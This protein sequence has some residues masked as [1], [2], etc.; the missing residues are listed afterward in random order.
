VRERGW[1]V[2]SLNYRLAPESAWPAQLQ[3]ATEALALLRSRADE[4]GIDLERIGGLGD[5]AG[6][7]LVALLGE[8]GP[9]RAPLRSV[10][11]WSGL[12]DLT[13]LTQ[14]PSSGG[15]PTSDGCTYRGLAA[16]VVDGLM[17]CTPQRC[18]DEYA[19]ASPAAT[20]SSGHAATLAVSSEGEQV[21][22]RQAWVMDAALQRNR[23]PSRVHVL[24]GSLHARGFQPYAWPLSLRFLAAT[25]TPE[26]APAYPR[27]SVTV[28]LD[29]PTR[30]GDA[31][32]PRGPAQGGRPAAA[33]RQQ[34]EPAGAAG[35]RDVAHGAARAAGARGGRHLLRHELDAARP[36]QHG[37]AGRLARQ[38]HRDGHLAAHGRGPV[39][40]RHASTTRLPGEQ[41]VRGGAV[42][43][44]LGVVGVVVV[45]VPF[46]LGRDDAPLWTTLLASLL[47]V[48]L[49][50]AL[51][52]LLRGA[53]ARRRAARRE[54]V[55]HRP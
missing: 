21:D 10:V 27:P 53:R 7:H 30:T 40:G 46:L 50:A 2:A 33:G 23:V 14:Q 13:G 3:D 38:R 28:T 4:L 32:R 48:G 1:T 31:G 5:S 15:C 16:K 52:G 29:L 19:L 35:R 45:V 44:G 24:P 49:G 36:R 42:L 9:G 20:V 26:T 54:R 22:P 11:T 37:L 55:V 51:L 17:A 12:N 34:R 6:G 8:P 39:T 43:F 18:P 25:L 47:P 41:L